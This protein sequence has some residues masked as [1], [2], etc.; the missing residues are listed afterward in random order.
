MK[1]KSYKKN[2]QYVLLFL[3]NTTKNVR[4]ETN[5]FQYIVQ[6]NIFV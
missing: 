6:E 1:K 4:K 2:L 5:L 3:S